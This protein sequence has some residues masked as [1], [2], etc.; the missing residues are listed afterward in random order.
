MPRNSFT[1]F[2]MDSVSDNPIPPEGSLSFADRRAY[3]QSTMRAFVQ[4]FAPIHPNLSVPHNTS[5]CEAQ[6]DK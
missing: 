6:R 2:A 1:I 3:L 5:E 4:Q